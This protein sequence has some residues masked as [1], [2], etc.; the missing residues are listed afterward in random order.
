MG[1]FRD[2][3]RWRLKSLGEGIEYVEM[4]KDVYEKLRI[5]IKDM[6]LPFLGVNDFFDEQIKNALDQYAQ[7]KEQ[8][9]ETEK[10]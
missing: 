8:R 9:E 5:A 7:W 1:F 6:D 3:A 4:R 10:S 2:A